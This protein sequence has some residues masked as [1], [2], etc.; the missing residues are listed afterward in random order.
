MNGHQFEYLLVESLIFV[1]DIHEG[2]AE[3]S[4]RQLVVWSMIWLKLI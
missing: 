3:N 4:P 1:I 2:C